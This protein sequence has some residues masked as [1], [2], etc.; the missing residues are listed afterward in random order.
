M[1]RVAFL[2][3]SL[4]RGNASHEPGNGAHSPFK[5][6]ISDRGN[7]P[8]MVGALAES[9]GA[10]WTVR[11]FGHGGRTVGADCNR[12]Y[13]ATTELAEA[14]RWS[15]K[16]CVLMLGTNDAWVNG[17]WNERAFEGEFE[18][19]SRFILKIPSRP[20]LAIVLPPPN[21]VERSARLL[22]HE[23]YPRISAVTSRLQ[24]ELPQKLEH[25]C[26]LQR[27][28][29]PI[30]LRPAFEAKC[31]LKSPQTEQVQA[32]LRRTQLWPYSR[33]FLHKWARGDGSRLQMSDGVHQ[34]AFGAAVIAE[35]VH[36]ALEPAKH[37][38]QVRSLQQ[39]RQRW[40][41]VKRLSLQG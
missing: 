7:Y 13:T 22:E 16:L 14:V 40:N 36:Q 4:T 25:G 2:G 39:A 32:D 41:G 31:R 3:D 37:G 5:F 38:C 17:C 9:Q 21:H 19:L 34:S 12:S 18:R 30:D 8:L 35:T 1:T 33:C 27:V 29:G 28:I 10:H 20:R 6:L 15:P 24:R 23:V 11:N 26:A